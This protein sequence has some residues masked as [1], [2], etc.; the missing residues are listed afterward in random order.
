VPRLS[1]EIRK[2]DARVKS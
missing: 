2:R 1:A